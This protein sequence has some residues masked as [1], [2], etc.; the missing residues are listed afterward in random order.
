M[1]RWLILLLL[2]VPIIG[3][4]R[5]N[6]YIVGHKAHANIYLGDWGTYDSPRRTGYSQ[7]WS[8][9]GVTAGTTHSGS[10]GVGDILSTGMHTGVS[11]QVKNLDAVLIWVGSNDYAVWNGTYEDIYDGTISGQ[12]LTDKE[13][14]IVSNIQSA[15][16]AINN[17]GIVKIFISNIIVKGSE[18]AASFPNETYRQRVIDSTTRVNTRIQSIITNNNNAYLMDRAGWVTSLLATYPLQES[19]YLIIGGTNVYVTTNSNNPIYFFLEDGDHYGTVISGVVANIC[20]IT[21][22]RSAGF[23]VPLLTD[24]QIIKQAG[25][26]SDN[27]IPTF[28]TIRIGIIG[29]SGTDEY[30]ADDNRG[31]DYHSVTF[32][33]IEL[34]HNILTN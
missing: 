22:L 12:N 10:G 11:A 14:S 16:T 33:P 8:L 7:N 31:G 21:P 20:I 29:D 24:A 30:Q 6:P 3:H 34:M 27:S 26:G 13:D 17:A 9:S 4:G 18:M 19:S 23:N 5:S 32:N 25:L 1:K 15:V 28:S 2:L